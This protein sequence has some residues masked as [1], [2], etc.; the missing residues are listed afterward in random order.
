MGAAAGSKAARH[1][2]ARDHPAFAEEL[3]RFLAAIWQMFNEFEIAG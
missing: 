3:P 1:D 2:A